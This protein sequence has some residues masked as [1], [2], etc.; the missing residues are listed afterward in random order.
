MQI[1]FFLYLPP[2]PPPPAPGLDFRFYLCTDPD[3][4]E[5][6]QIFLFWMRS[7]PGRVWWDLPEWLQCLTANDKVGNSPG[8]DP[9]ILWHSG[10]WVAADEAVFNTVKEENKIP[11]FPCYNFVFCFTNI[12]QSAWKFKERLSNI[13]FYKN[14]LPS[15]INIT[16][17]GPVPLCDASCGRGPHPV[18]RLPWLGQAHGAHLRQE[19]QAGVL[20]ASPAHHA[21]RRGT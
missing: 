16:T 4:K 8:F 14:L 21:S 7:S 19:V 1:H 10:F 9:S 2:P 3:L 5:K 12:L 13:R 15:D 17:I 20:G 11:K 6:T 18:G